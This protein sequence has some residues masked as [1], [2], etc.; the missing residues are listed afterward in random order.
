MSWEAAGAIGEIAG[1]IAVIVT[2]IYLSRQIRATGVQLEVNAVT[3]VA[4]LWNDAFSPIVSDSHS[5][6]VWVDGMTDPSTLDDKDRVLFELFMLR[7]FNPFEIVVTHYLKGTMD[8]SMETN[9][10]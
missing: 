7:I 3:D 5:M 8:E 2:L 9:D 1:A 4:A 10:Q 6:T